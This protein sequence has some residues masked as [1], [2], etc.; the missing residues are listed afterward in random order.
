MAEEKR[1]LEVKV[2]LLGDSA[3]GKSKLVERYLMGK[4][5]PKMQS[6]H[7]LTWF[8]HEAELGSGE[9]VLVNFWDTA[10]QERFNS[11]HDSYYHGAHAAVLVFDVQRK[12]TYKNLE[13]W[14]NEMRRMRP[15]IPVLVAANKIDLDMNVTKKEFN[16][17]KKHDLKLHYVSAA[18]GVNVV[19]MFQSAIEAGVAYLRDPDKQDTVQQVLEFLREDAARNPEPA[20]ED[21]KTGED[22]AE[23]P[24]PTAPPAPEA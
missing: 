15:E 5:C 3:V 17:T 4:F 16:F 9:K 8:E 7:A 1:K 19:E 23:P 11:M 14:L 10:G 22:G 21:A 20:P 2:I 18:T 12:P 13:T 24:A 6:T